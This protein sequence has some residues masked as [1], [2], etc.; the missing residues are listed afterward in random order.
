MRLF[1]AIAFPDPTLDALAQVAD[2]L[3]LRAGSASIAWETRAKLHNTLKFLGE[4]AEDAVPSLVRV[5]AEVGARHR[6]FE[7]DFARLSAFP[8]EDVPRILWFGI[9]RGRDSVVAIAEDVDVSLATLGFDRETRPYVPHVT[10]GRTKGRAGERAARALLEAPRPSLADVP[11]AHVG[12]FVL[13]A[14]R[15]QSYDVLHEIDLGPRGVP[16]GGEA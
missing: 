8:A 16:A 11:R 14:S 2:G 10:I 13:M 6:R 12:S 15:N 1:F 5:A 7:I 9:E 4:V 3:R